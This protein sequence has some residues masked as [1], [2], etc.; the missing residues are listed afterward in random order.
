MALKTVTLDAELPATDAPDAS[1]GQQ[2]GR[3][4]AAGKPAGGRK[5]AL[6]IIG[7]VVAVGALAVGGNWFLN[8]RF[9]IATDNAYVRSDITNVAAK[10]QG[11]VAS[12]NIAANQKVKAGDLLFSIDNADYKARVAEAQAALSQAQADAQQAKAR[13]AAQAAAVASAKSRAAAQRDQLTEAQATSDWQSS[14]LKRL[15]EL[16]DKGWYPKA[17]VEQAQSTEKAARAGVTAQRSQVVSAEA[18]INQA[19]QEYTASTASAASADA[20]VAA[21]KAK[22]DAAQLELSR[23]EVH[24]AIDGTIANNTVVPGALLSPGQQV[25][26]IVPK[27]DA[28]IIANYK[29]TQVAQMAQGQHVRLKV[30]AYPDLK[31]T[32]VVDS[33]APASGGTFSLIP[34]DTATGNFTKIVQRVPVKILIDKDCLATGKMRS[35]LS[36][37]ATV[38]TKAS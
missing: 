19:Q 25:V 5:L 8:G 21:A 23:T 18:A 33:I 35:G 10:V 3:Q 27:D 17:R 36:I 15:S 1:L 37:V 26:S 31:C 20:R 32:G 7:G 13:I 6:P 24:A 11:Y 30:D 28:Y 22:L 29:E 16:A 38:S 34:Q 2:P 14:D 9:E 12:V 4:A